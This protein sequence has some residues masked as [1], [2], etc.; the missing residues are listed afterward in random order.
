MLILSA[1]LLLIVF[2]PLT[3]R[4]ACNSASRNKDLQV[5][6]LGTPTQTRAAMSHDELGIV[7]VVLT[8]PLGWSHG[9]RRVGCALPCH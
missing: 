3:T 4:L 9:Q 6:L 5:E 1:K 8:C 7:A 2:L